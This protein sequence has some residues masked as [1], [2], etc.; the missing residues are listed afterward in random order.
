M[1]TDNNEID[2]EAF[3]RLKKELLITP[4]EKTSPY[5]YYI[6]LKHDTGHKFQQLFRLT[7]VRDE[8]GNI[9]HA[10]YRGEPITVEEWRYLISSGRLPSKIWVSG[11]KVHIDAKR[12]T[13]TSKDKRTII[14]LFKV[15][16]SKVAAQPD[17]DVEFATAV[18]EELE[19]LEANTL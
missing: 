18:S 16:A 5:R 14:N 8:E 2:H 13:L 4:Y 10:I 3:K 6:N 19:L 9:R 7:L 17:V 1:R 15:W 11:G 12:L